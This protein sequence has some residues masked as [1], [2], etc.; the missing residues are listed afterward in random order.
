M[1][2]AYRGDD[3]RYYWAEDKSRNLFE[4]HKKTVLEGL[5]LLVKDFNLLYA[6]RPDS[7]PSDGKEN[8][9][10]TMDLRHDPVNATKISLAKRH[11]ESGY[12]DTFILYSDC[13]ALGGKTDSFMLETMLMRGMQ[14][15]ID[16]FFRKHKELTSSIGEIITNVNYGKPLEGTCTICTYLVNRSKG[17]RGG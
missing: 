13:Y 16:L 17:T 4:E 14:R 12:Q 6:Y 7:I 2:L 1:G 3:G 5:E 10:N 8:F 11:L 15:N 9:P